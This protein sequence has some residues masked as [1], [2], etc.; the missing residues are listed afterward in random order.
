[1]KSQ[2][3]DGR[4]RPQV[5]QS[6]EPLPHG[7]TKL[8][9]GLPSFAPFDDN[10]ARGEAEH[11]KVS[12]RDQ[13]S[14]RGSFEL[15]GIPYPPR[16]RAQAIEAVQR[17]LAASGCPLHPPELVARMSVED[18]DAFTEFDPLIRYMLDAVEA[19]TLSGPRS[20]TEYLMHRMNADELLTDRRRARGLAEAPHWDDVATLARA[21][22]LRTPYVPQSP[23]GAAI[24]RL[25]ER[26]RLAE[27]RPRP[28]EVSS[29]D[30]RVEGVSRSMFSEVRLP[31][32]PSTRANVIEMLKAVRRRGWPP[33]MAPEFVA[34]MGSPD[35]PV[36]T[37][38]LIGYESYEL[39]ALI[40]RPLRSA[41]R[42]SQRQSGY[43]R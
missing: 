33:L 4:L 26:E 14:I 34:R 27:P 38:R 43:G 36:V 37:P 19:R 6:E 21:A 11:W 31:Y 22:L 28:E 7:L 8:L 3:F 10:R 12:E 30:A 20:S 13:L 23:M 32:P 29:L 9:N 15:A 35:V 41:G 42:G 2:P 1:V 25:I 18:N 17:I 16:T 24:A 5:G 39:C 40:V